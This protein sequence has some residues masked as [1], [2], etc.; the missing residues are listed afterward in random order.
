MSAM[1]ESNAGGETD[2]N[3]CHKHGW[4]NEDEI[5]EL[6]RWIKDLEIQCKACEA[7]RKS[8]CQDLAWVHHDYARKEKALKESVH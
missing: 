6:T 2:I 3:C 7:E 5:E 8:L 4:H 1:E